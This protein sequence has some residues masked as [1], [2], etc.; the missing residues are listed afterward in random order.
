M[1]PVLPESEKVSFKILKCD[2]NI[3]IDSDFKYGTYIMSF[4]LLKI[5]EGDDTWTITSHFKE[6][7]FELLNIR[8]RIN[9]K[10]NGNLKADPVKRE[11]QKACHLIYLD[12]IKVHNEEP[13]HFV[14]TYREKLAATKIGY[15]YFLFKRHFV[16]FYK[17]FP[18]YCSNFK[19]QVQFQKKR[20][21]ILASNPNDCI[22]GKKLLLTKE[23]IS[24]FEYTTLSF[25]I[26]SGLLINKHSAVIEKII[27]SSGIIAWIF[28]FIIDYINNGSE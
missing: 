24:P 8:S 4:D 5:S 25:M 6:D 9:G 20:V 3:T 17:M 12:K 26:I 18:N 2:L 19:M 28:K 1:T 21:K 23:H 7:D 16:S 27:W 13:Y 22:R 11:D 15:G 14:I 10:L